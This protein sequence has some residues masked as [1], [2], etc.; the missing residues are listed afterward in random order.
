MDIKVY[1]LIGAVIFGQLGFVSYA[2]ASPTSQF[3]QNITAGTLT[4]D[5][6][7]GSYQTVAN[8]GVQ[9][10]NTSF[11]FNCQTTNGTFGSSTQ[12]IYVQN[13][14]ASDSGWT[15]SL[16]ASNETDLWTDGGT[17]Q[18]DY[19]DY[20]AAGLLNCAD[21]ASDTDT[22]GGQMSVNPAAGTLAAG[23]CSGCTTG[24]IT[25]GSL[26]KFG[27]SVTSSITLLSA[28]AGSDDIG[29]WKLTGVAVSQK[30]PASQPSAVY[31]LS[32]TLSITA[33]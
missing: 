33:I 23:T 3:S 8:P 14:D 24:S 9:M 30:I 27:E 17:N 31:T 5:I 29:D 26:D 4:R 13:P 12:M 10:S 1:A 19:N 7:D 20:D 22:K 2:M 6:V 32:L 11:S 25:K 18:F 15:L 16:A 21:T 28:A